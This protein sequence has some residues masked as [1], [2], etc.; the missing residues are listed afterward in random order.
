MPQRDR[1]AFIRDNLQVADVAGCPGVKLYVARPDSGLS[2]LESVAAPYW[3]WPWPGGL[4][5]AR[6][7]LE[8]P[9]TVAGRRVLDLGAGSGL[10]GIVAALKGAS[11]VIAADTDRNARAAV[12]ENAAL[13]GVRI[14]TVAADLLAGP[15]P[16]ADLDFDVIL[17]GDVFYE[18]DLAAR[19]MA[20]LRRTR[21]GGAEVLLGDIGRPSFPAN[22]LV[23]VARYPV[24]D[25]G[26]AESAPPHAGGVYVLA[27]GGSVAGDGL[28]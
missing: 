18:P 4:A 25:V 5:L 22:G 6:H 24:P 20:F 12:R 11:E 27:G 8:C 23:R 16:G 1:R 14:R 7:L 21:Q 15:A 19:A 26:D 28:D 2:R 9:R 10:V 17:A 3:A 13:N